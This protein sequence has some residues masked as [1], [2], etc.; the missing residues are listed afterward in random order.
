MSES[1]F[2]SRVGDYARL[3]GWLLWHEADSRRNTAG[4]PDL[5]MLRERLVMAE[6]KSA[7]G[8]PTVQQ[9]NVLALLAAAGVESYLWRPADWNQVMEVLA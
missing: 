3:R 6:L 9:R 8:R 4:L 7:S 2:Q 1:D 5:I